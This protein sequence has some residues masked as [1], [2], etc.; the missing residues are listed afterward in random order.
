MQTDWNYRSDTNIFL[1]ES[2]EFVVQSRWIGG[3]RLGYSNADDTMDIAVVGRNI[4]D[5]IVADGALD[6]LIQTAFVNE[7]AYLGYGVQQE[8][9]IAMNQCVCNLK[10]PCIISSLRRYHLKQP[11]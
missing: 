9:L 11:K 10:R 7:P 1:Y 4:S 2:I 3:L 8:L 5:E 6:F